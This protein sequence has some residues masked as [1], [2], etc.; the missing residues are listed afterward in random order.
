MY[1]VRLFVT[2][3]LEVSFEKLSKTEKIRRI[4]DILFVSYL[5]LGPYG[6]GSSQMLSQTDGVTADA[7][8]IRMSRS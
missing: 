5:I 8:Q 1:I 2:F 7:T 3:T 4:T 6:R